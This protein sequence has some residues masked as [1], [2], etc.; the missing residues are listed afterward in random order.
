MAADDL[1]IKPTW[2]IPEEPKYA[3]II[4]E[5]E[6]FKKDYQNLSST[7]IERFKLIFEGMSDAD[8][9]TLYEHYKGRYGGYD[10]FT[11]KAS[12]IPSYINGYC[13]LGGGD[14]TGRWVDGSFKNTPK[15]HSWDIEL[16]FEKSI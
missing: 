5:S 6:N 8:A 7:P 4:T 1:Q 2:V 13:D 9:E 12:Y 10:E 14:L 11:W 3:N 16:V 15:S